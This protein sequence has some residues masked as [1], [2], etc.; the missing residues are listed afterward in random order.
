MTYKHTLA[1]CYTGYIVQ[2]IVNNLAPLLFITFERRLGL[3]LGLISI[4]ATVNFAVQTTVD[5]LFA[6]VADRLGYRKTAISAHIFV[7]AGL[8]GLS[9]LPLIMPPFAGILIS[10]IFYAVGGGLLEVLISPML[11][12]LP[13]ENKASAMSLLHSFY[14]WGQ[15]G[16]VLLS[17]LFFTLAGSGSWRILP[18][19]WTAVPLANIILFAKVPIVRLEDNTPSMPKRELVRKRDFWIFMAIML[20]AGASEQGM[21]QWASAFAEEGLGV[22]KTLGDLLGPCMF[23][24]LM[25]GSRAFYGKNGKKISLVKFMTL[26][27]AVCVFAYAA[28]ALSPLPLPALAG[29][30]LCGLCVGIMWPGTF[31]L[32][33]RRV[34]AGGTAMFALLALAGDIGCA[35]GPTLVGFSGS[36]RSG[37]LLSAL[38][39]AALVLLMPAV[40][41]KRR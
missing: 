19:L 6:A 14:C 36:I 12:A 4:L 1:A 5:F 38:F 35:L 8:L 30:A 20:C 40:N 18:L 32:A 15:V 22:S 33:S 2:A 39:P 17:T 26:C 25:G 16:V 11:E 31:S 13:L 34:P 24:L 28:A 21:S 10:V 9:L 27:G 41:G 7:V 3:N 23:A 29:C 37:L